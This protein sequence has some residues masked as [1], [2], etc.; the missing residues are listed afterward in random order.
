VH[1]DVVEWEYRAGWNKPAKSLSSM[2]PNGLTMDQELHVKNI[3]IGER[4]DL[5]S[6]LPNLCLDIF[7]KTIHVSTLF[8]K[9]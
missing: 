8:E 5:R 9:S 7:G 4:L 3:R 1:E 6:P 2:A